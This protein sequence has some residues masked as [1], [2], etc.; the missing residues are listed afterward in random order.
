MFKDSYFKVREISLFCHG[1]FH[2]P[3]IDAELVSI[4]F[5]LLAYC[6]VVDE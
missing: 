2:V 3:E 6:K 5:V 4:H 1:L